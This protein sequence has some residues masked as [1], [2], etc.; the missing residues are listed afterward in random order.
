MKRLLLILLL[1]PFS[2]KAEVRL[3]AILSDHMVLQRAE[4]VPVW[5][6]AA[7]Q[8]QVTVTVAGYSQSTR[9]APDGNWRVEFNLADA[10]PAATV[11]RVRGASNELIVTDVLLGQV[12]LASGQSNMQKPLGEQKGQLPTFGAEAEIAAA[13][14]PELRLFKV[15]RN[16]QKQPAGDVK[17]SWVR[18]SPATIVESRFSAAAYYF[19]RRVQQALKQP[20]G[21]IDASVGGTRI[22][23]WTPPATGKEAAA[24]AGD[25]VLYNGMIAGLAPFAIKGVL[26]YQG[27]SNII[28]NDDGAAYTPRMAA[29]VEGW[30]RQWRADFPFYYVQ[31]APHLYSVVRPAHL[32]HGAE[33]E[34][35]LW[36][37][38]AQALR[39]PNTAMIVT[40]DLVDDLR[41]IH[42]RDKR[43]VGLRLANLALAK[44]YGQGGIEPFGPTYRSIEI[45]GDKAVLKFDHADGLASRD[46]KPLDWFEIAG[47]DGRFQPALAT[48]DGA[49]IVVRSG[50]VDRPVSVRFAWH[51]AAQPNLVNRAG[52]PAVPF[53]SEK[54][55]PSNALSR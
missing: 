42:P 52:L 40:T 1:C 35:M 6:W 41:D 26:W 45:V 21:L 33:S 9:A 23:L 7:P 8:E 31:V 4:R 2:L 19:G 39:I 37:A 15:A 22:E 12:W 54:P 51:E 32:L 48:I 18:C 10:A 5:G 46:G 50:A 13:D 27:E 20:V 14:H 38:Q 44:S 29:L 3:P 17:G 28:D 55:I 49:G 53:R 25:S 36:E 24:P 11:M 43:S 47:D 30:R 16:A 34:P